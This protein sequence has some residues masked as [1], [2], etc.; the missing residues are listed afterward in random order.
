MK[1]EPESLF[2]KYFEEIQK[3]IECIQKTELKNISIASDLV[4]NSLI[5]D[6]IVHVFGT[7]HSLILAEEVFYRA[8]GLAPI[9]PLL[10]AGVSLREGGTRSTLME[11]LEGYAKVISNYYNLEE[12]DVIIIVSNSGRNAVPIEMAIEAKKKGLKVV[13]I[14]SVEFSKSAPSRHSSG[15]Y[16]F[17]VADIIINN[18]VPPGDA[19]I[20]L[21]GLEQKMGPIS[22][23][24]NAF[25][26][27]L[28]M[29]LAAQKMLRFGKTPPVWVSANIEG[30]DEFN[31]KFIRK[32]KNRIKHM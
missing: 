24:I 15:K 16:L 5:N 19:V 29:M 7:G 9:N 13:A 31:E 8:G 20:K 4:T 22:T 3:R 1:D 11:R 2:E 12:K 30:G 14:T 32:Y 26:L 17:D 25:I 10:D 21:E 6:G 27:H 23:I 18:Y 28:I